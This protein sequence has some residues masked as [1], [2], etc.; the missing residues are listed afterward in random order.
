MDKDGPTMPFIDRRP[1]SLA[2]ERVDRDRAS[3]NA[4]MRI[5]A[6]TPRGYVLDRARHSGTRTESNAGGDDTP[7]TSVL[8]GIDRSVNS[9]AARDQAALFASPGGTVKLVP[10]PHLTHHGD[11]ALRDACAGH[12]LLALGADACAFRAVGRVSLPLLIARWCPLP[13]EVASTILVAVD[14]S[15]ASGRAVELA[16]RLAAAHRGSVVLV[17]TPPRDPALERAIAASRRILVR[18]TGAAPRLIG[19]QL[20]PEEAIR[21]AA[22]ALTASLVVL[23]TGHSENARRTAAQLVSRVGSSVLAV[24]A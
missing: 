13:S 16:G 9:R 6:D 4:P 11:R 7:F 12:D 17:A 5:R 18:T 15:S 21:A 14:G 24:P 2:R 22:Y 20:P 3:G 8:C 1:G 19:E 10:A 23:G